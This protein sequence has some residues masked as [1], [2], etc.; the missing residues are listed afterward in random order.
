[1]RRRSAPCPASTAG[2]RGQHSP[3]EN[4]FVAGDWTA[5]GWPATMEGAV[6]SGYLAAEAVLRS[7]G[8]AVLQPDLAERHLYNR[9]L[10][11]QSATDR[12]AVIARPRDR[13]GHA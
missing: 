11:V 9:T 5:T 13:S 12:V 4:L 2:G 8:N 10:R 1:M 3:I 6:R 7:A